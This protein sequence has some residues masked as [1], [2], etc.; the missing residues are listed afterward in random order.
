ML[1]V[2]IGCSFAMILPVGNP[3]NAIVFDA[4]TMKTFDM[5]KPGLI[6][7]VLCCIVE[8]FMIQTLGVALFNL[9]TFPAWAN[10]SYVTTVS[11]SS[12]SSN[13]TIMSNVSSLVNTTLQNGR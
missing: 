2:T 13:W 4:S 5:M 12:F 7:K 3:S 9:Q 10:S 11:S 8:L 1:P 6:L